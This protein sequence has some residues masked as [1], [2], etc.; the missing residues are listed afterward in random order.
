MDL[1]GKKAEKR[2][3]SAEREKSRDCRKNCAVVPALFRKRQ[4]L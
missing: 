3:G 4:V 2:P 1:H